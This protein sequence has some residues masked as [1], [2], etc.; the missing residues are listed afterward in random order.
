MIE[1][2]K[3]IQMTKKKLRDTGAIGNLSFIETDQFR[4]L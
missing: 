4:L 3:D 2:T 1:K